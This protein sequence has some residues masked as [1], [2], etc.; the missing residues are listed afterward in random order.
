MILEAMTRAHGRH[1]GL[2]RGGRSSRHQPLLQPG[3]SVALNWRA[4]LDEHL[5]SFQVEGL[6]LRAAR[7]MP[8]AL[9]LNVL[10]SVAALA[11][12]L[13]ERDP[14][15]A[16]FEQLVLLAEHMDDADLAPALM[17]RLELSMLAELG[18]G[19]D[20]ERCVATGVTDDL[21][22]VS[23]RS[24]RAVS[25]GAGAPYHRKLLALP[26]F[27]RAGFT[28]G[29]PDAAQVL[30]GFAITGHFL[31]RH[32]YEPRGVAPPDG[33]ARVVEIVRSRAAGP[34]TSPTAGGPP[35]NGQQAG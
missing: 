23:P 22:Y 17:V 27:L 28:S 11:R 2:V 13:P 9:A 21:V 34:P 3:N 19:L 29:A 1:L 14:H 8:S 24:G 20:L 35:P 33:R 32:V 10:G 7:Y 15:P 5:G 16:V 6:T 18:F 31:L 30:A 12:M 4:R 26:P 25:A